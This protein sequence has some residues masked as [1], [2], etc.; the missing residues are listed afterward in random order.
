MS[1][2]EGRKDG[3]RSRCREH[4]C[5]SNQCAASA[6]RPIM[7]GVDKVVTPDMCVYCFDVLIGH[8]SRAHPPK[9]PFFPNDE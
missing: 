2:E 8:L 5:E 3:K 7:N 9:N 1:R 4:H 6:E